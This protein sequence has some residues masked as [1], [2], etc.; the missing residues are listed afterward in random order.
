MRDVI[1]HLIDNARSGDR[2]GVDGEQIAPLEL[3][4]ESIRLARLATSIHL[5]G[6]ARE[7]AA[8]T[9]VRDRAL[10]MREPMR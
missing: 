4:A 6:T 9:P 7:I 10:S 1:R 8:A 5:A 3:A 2:V